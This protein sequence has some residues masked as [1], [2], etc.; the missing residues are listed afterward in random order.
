MEPNPHITDAA[1]GTD[2][3]SVALDRKATAVTATQLGEN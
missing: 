2:D 1:T 3:R